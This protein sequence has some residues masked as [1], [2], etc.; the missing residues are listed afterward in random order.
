MKSM[1][2]LL[3]FLSGIVTQSFSLIPPEADSASSLQKSELA[4]MN[5]LRLALRRDNVQTMRIKAS[6]NVSLNDFNQSASAVIRIAGR[7]SLAMDIMAFGIPVAKLYMNKERFAFL[8]L[9]NG[10]FVEGPATA[11]NMANVTNIPLSFE[12]FIC[13]L[14]CES[15]SPTSYYSHEAT[16]STGNH[17]FRYDR[18]DNNREFVVLNPADIMMKQY[19]R[20]SQDGSLLMNVV[21]A[22]SILIDS[23][24]FPQKVQVQAPGSKFT[25][26]VHSEEIVINKEMKEP[27]IFPVPQGIEREQLN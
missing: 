10:R 2:F 1:Y 14:R 19:Q 27:F 3:M 20:K 16:T 15:P 18:P 17:V 9:F 4:T 6:L 26:S 5:N 21:Y 24:T 25:M 22:E 7:D 8:D 13:L 12:D 23:L 11:A